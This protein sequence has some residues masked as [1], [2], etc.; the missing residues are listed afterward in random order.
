MRRIIALAVAVLALVLISALPASATSSH[1][2]KPDGDGVHFDQLLPAGT[3]CSFD[4]VAHVFNDQDAWVSNGRLMFYGY[5]SVRLVNQ[6]NGHSVWRLT[7]GPGYVDLATGVAHDRGRW[8]VEVHAHAGK[9]ARLL[10]VTGTFDTSPLY[11]VPF[12]IK[13]GT[14][15]EDACA[16]IA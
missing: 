11:D 13:K 9:A 15:I 3:A 2:P 16:L 8:I 6:S 5:G 4:V 12:N 1:A 10:F 7:D 14:R